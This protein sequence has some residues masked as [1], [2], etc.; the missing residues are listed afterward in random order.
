MKTLFLTLIFL[1]ISN[2]TY[3]QFR[4]GT[5]RMADSTGTLT[6]SAPIKSWQSHWVKMKDLDSTI[7]GPGLKYTGSGL[8]LKIGPG[9]YISNDTLFV[10]GLSNKFFDE[11]RIIADLETPTINFLNVLNED[12]T[13]YHSLGADI[14]I[15]NSLIIKLL[16]GAHPATIFYGGVGIGDDIS[17]Q[18]HEDY[19]NRLA[20]DAERVDILGDTLTIGG[21][22]LVARN[23]GKFEVANTLVTFGNFESG[24]DIYFEGYLKVGNSLTSETVIKYD[25]SLFPKLVVDNVEPDDLEYGQV[26]L[27]YDTDHLYWLIN[28]DGKNWKVQLQ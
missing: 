4:I 10:E 26:I 12:D 8:T 22:D 18:E 13:N 5:V 17:L 2:I 6:V 1:I 15:N 28:V 9:L 23:D 3:S 27:W 14:K 19:P 24:R 21:Q 7:A 20:I 11:I 25:R 16:A